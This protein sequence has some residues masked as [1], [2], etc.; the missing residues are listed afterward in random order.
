M[1]HCCAKTLA[2]RRET[3]DDRPFQPTELTAKMT[4]PTTNAANSSA[5]SLPVYRAADLCV[6]HGANLGDTLTIADEIEPNDIY[7]LSDTAAPVRLGLNAATDDTL[8]VAA[9]TETGSPGAPVRIDCCLTLMSPGGQ[10]TELLVLAQHGPHDEAEIIHALPL[11]ALSPRTDCTVVR[12]DTTG[13]RAKLA[14][15]A[16]VSFARGT[17]IT[18]ASGAQVPIEDLDV[19]DRVLTRD[20]GVQPI[21]WI[22]QN[23]VRAVGEYAPIVI[24]AGALNN[25]R[26]LVISPEHRLFIYQRDDALGA[27]RA[28]VLVRAR[29]LVNGSSVTRRD[30]GFVD[31]FQLL[32]DAHHIIYAEGIAA[33]T[34]LLSPQTRPALPEDLSHQMAGA[35]PGHEGRA[36]L[37]FEVGETLL[38][39]PDTAD[40][41]RRA[42]T[43]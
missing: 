22:G 40:I 39:H 43:R 14:E 16:C 23:T 32:F 2:T 11:A 20:D 30:G 10:T 3:A 38:S 4:A 15:I 9:N 21:R 27:G 12:I 42:S 33:E 7:T 19:G 36:H 25:S 29:H 37:T 41:L 17:H 26:D 28:E 5:F 24:A 8:T 13:L 35:L 1:T 31:Y 6:T 18:L 34:L